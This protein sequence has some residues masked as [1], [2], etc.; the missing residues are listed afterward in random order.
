MVRWL[1]PDLNPTL[2]AVGLELIGP[3]PRTVANIDNLVRLF[4]FAD[5]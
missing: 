3:S 5:R 4:G 1:G 2:R